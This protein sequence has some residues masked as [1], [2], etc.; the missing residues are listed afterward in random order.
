MKFVLLTPER[1]PEVEPWFDDPET[2]RYLGGRDWVRRALALM[3]QTPGQEFQGHMVLR[4]NVWIASEERLP[5]ALIDVESYDDGSAAFAFVVAPKMRGRGV[6]TRLLNN[7]L[8][9]P[10]LTTVRTLIGYVEPDNPAS[11]RCLEKA[12]F[13]IAVE[14]DAEGLLPISRPLYI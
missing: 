7:V 10:E 13:S 14:P 1:L 3:Q 8:G 12:G 6:G 9:L 5:V 4:R 2:V 11:R